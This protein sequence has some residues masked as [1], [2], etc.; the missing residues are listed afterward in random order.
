L[1]TA[2]FLSLYGLVFV[3]V[4]GYV[5]RRTTAHGLVQPPAAAE[6]WTIAA[7]LAMGLALRLPMLWDPGFHYDTGTF[8]AWALTASD[9]AAPLH[10]Y[11]EGYFAHYP[12]FYMVV[13]AGLGALVR[14]I[15]WEASSHFTALIKLPALL[16]DAATA[17]LLL[18]ELKPRLGEGRGWGLASLYWLNPVMIFAGAL[19]GQVESLLCLLLVLGWLAW[20]SGRVY[21][22]AAAFAVAV[23]FRP[24]GVLYA[25]IFG[26]AL[27][28]SAGWRRNAA[29]FAVGVVT[30]SAIVLPFAWSRSLDWLLSLYSGTAGGQDFITTT[31]G[32]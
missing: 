22:A 17:L 10:V 7:W 18:R 32:R 9:P 25:A 12:P 20:R 5:V 1:D 2:A 3:V 13:L 8:K 6:G 29:A 24:Q 26:V 16:A 15:G 11:K 14:L 28:S 21:L 19:W 4:A 31:S 30:Y 27:L 23:A